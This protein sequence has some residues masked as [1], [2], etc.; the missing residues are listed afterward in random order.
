[1]RP[2]TLM[3]IIGFLMIVAPVDAQTPGKWIKGAAFPEPSEEL[4]GAS[5]EGKCHVFGGLGQGWVPQG[6]MYA[7]DP[8]AA[9]WTKKQ[10]T[11]LP[12]HHVAF[13][14]LDGKVLRLRRLC[15]TGL[16]AHQ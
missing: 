8:A 9:K 12:S 6:L 7:Y 4:V 3:A 14:E 11:A 1:M 2:L 13:T 5:V 16:S 10:P 15:A